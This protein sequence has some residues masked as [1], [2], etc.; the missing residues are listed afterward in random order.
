MLINWGLS[1]S[2]RFWSKRIMTYYYTA[3]PALGAAPLDSPWESPIWQAADGGPH[4]P[5]PCRRQP[6]SAHRPSRL[7]YDAEHSICGSAWKIATWSPVTLGFK[8]RSGKIAAWSSSRSRGPPADIS[9]SRSTAAGRCSAATSRIRPARPTAL[10]ASRG[11]GRSTASGSGLRIRCRRPSCRS[12]RARSCGTSL[13][14]SRWRRWSPTRV[15]WPV[16]RPGMAGQLLQVCRRQ[17]ASPLGQLGPHRRGVEL[18]SAGLL[19][20]DSLRKRS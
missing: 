18:P 8:S 19:C 6:P 1:L 14:R 20:T 4:R 10:P 7:L 11:C 16:G 2:C 12:S 9:I 15:H 3:Y 17:F 5:V 13:A